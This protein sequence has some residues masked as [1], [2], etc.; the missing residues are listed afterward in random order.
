MIG[1][2]IVLYFLI[3]IIVSYY[4]WRKWNETSFLMI[5]ITWP[6]FVMVEIGGTIDV[7]LAKL[8]IFIY[9]KTRRG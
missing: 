5:A 1:I 3:G 6:I 8:F 4:I 2:G 7:T 9:N